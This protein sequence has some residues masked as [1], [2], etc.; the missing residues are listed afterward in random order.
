MKR[1]RKYVAFDLHQATTVAS[2]RVA[3]GRVIARSILPTEEP[4]LVEF[5][6]PHRRRF[7]RS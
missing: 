3:S 7:R 5:S 1:T 6:A 4:A 2:V